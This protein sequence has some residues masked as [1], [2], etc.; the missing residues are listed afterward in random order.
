MKRFLAIFLCLALAFSMSACG[1]DESKAGQDKDGKKVENGGGGKSAK[2]MAKDLLSKEDVEQL[3]GLE[4]SEISD[5]GEN[6]I[7]QQVIAYHVGESGL[8]Q[9]SFI[10]NTEE[11]IKNI[12]EFSK[13]EDD[14]DLEGLGD[15]AYMS[16]GGLLGDSVYIMKGEYEVHITTMYIENASDIALEAA[17]LSFKRLEKRIK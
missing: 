2:I 15:A 17:K 8:V 6:Q 11:S 12:F 5:H 7:G 4:V 16:V 1:S 3:T 14:I 9:I 10:H 13:S